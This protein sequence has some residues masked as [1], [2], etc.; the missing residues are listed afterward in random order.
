MQNLSLQHF[1][2]EESGQKEATPSSYDLFAV[3][4]HQGSI[5]AGHYMAVCKAPSPPGSKE[6]DQWYCFNDVSVNKLAASAVPSPNAYL[7]C[8]Y[9]KDAEA[10]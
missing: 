10:K 9:R 7:L 4:N 2:S 1:M 8:Y 3:S 6:K 5:A